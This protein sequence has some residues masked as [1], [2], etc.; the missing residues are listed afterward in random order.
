M[1]TTSPRSRTLRSNERTVKTARQA[2]LTVFSLEVRVVS[3]PQGFH[4]SQ[5]RILTSKNG[6]KF[7]D[8][9]PALQRETQPE[10]NQI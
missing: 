6:Q 9:L 10:R 4:N 1:E 7:L 2:M 5:L 3:R 8:K